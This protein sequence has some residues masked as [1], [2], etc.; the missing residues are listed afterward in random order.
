[1]QIKN[2][3]SPRVGVGS[4]SRAL[5]DKVSRISSGFS[6]NMPN[7]RQIVVRGCKKIAVY[8]P[9]LISLSLGKRYISVCGKKL[10]CT[11]FSGRDVGICGEIRSFFFSENLPKESDEI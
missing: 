2:K 8:S 7:E 6:L 4:T 9:V 11:V 5:V 3:K 10:V 1:M